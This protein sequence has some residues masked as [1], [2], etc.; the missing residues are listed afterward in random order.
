[1]DN[2]NNNNADGNEELSGYE[3]EREVLKRQIE[4]QV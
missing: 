1:M 3:S 4:E 2:N